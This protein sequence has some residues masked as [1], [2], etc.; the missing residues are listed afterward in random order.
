[1]RLLTL[2]FLTSLCTCVRAQNFH[3]GVVP[4]G[5][6]VLNRRPF[7][8]LTPSGDLVLLDVRG[9]NSKI[10]VFRGNNKTPSEEIKIGMNNKD[11]QKVEV[12]PDGGLIVLGSKKKSLL[13]EWFSPE[14]DTAYLRHTSAVEFNN[15]PDILSCFPQAN[16]A[17]ALFFT[18]S[19]KGVGKTYRWPLKLRRDTIA[20][21]P[22][23]V[24][25]PPEEVYDE[26]LTAICRLPNGRFAGLGSD[27]NRFYLQYFGQSGRAE[28]GKLFLPVNLF[29]DAQT[30][31]YHP[32]TKGIVV[33][34]TKDENTPWWYLFDLEGKTI[35]GKRGTSKNASDLQIKRILV[36]PDNS[37]AFLGEQIKASAADFPDLKTIW[38]ATVGEELTGLTTRVPSPDTWQGEA[39]YL[40]PRNRLLATGFNV[41]TKE[42]ILGRDA[43]ANQEGD[44]SKL[45]F[46]PPNLIDQQG[47]KVLDA[48]EAAS[49]ALPWASSE[50]R[51]S[52]IISATLRFSKTIPGLP[53]EIKSNSLAVLG[54]DQGVIHIPLFGGKDLPSGRH[55][56]TIEL[57]H[58]GQFVSS[59][60]YTLETR[61]VP[62]SNV[63]FAKEYCLLSFL[64]D[65]DSASFQRLD[66]LEVSLRVRNDGRKT[67]TGINLKVLPI[68]HVTFSDYYFEF[69]DLAP[70]EYRDTSVRVMAHSYFEYEDL[71]LSF[72][73]DDD[74][75]ANSF[76]GLN[77]KLDNVFLMKGSN[78]N[79]IVPEFIDYPNG[80]RGGPS[81]YFVPEISY[82]TKMVIPDP[83]KLEK[84]TILSPMLRVP[85]RFQIRSSQHFTIESIDVTIESKAS[86]K[87][88]SCGGGLFPY[89]LNGPPHSNIYEFQ[90]DLPVK[91]EKDTYY[92]TF[93]TDQG[94]V[95]S[96]DTLHIEPQKRFKKNLHICMIAPRYNGNEPA[97]L[98]AKMMDSLL[99]KHQLT[100]NVDNRFFT[101]VDTKVILNATAEN[102]YNYLKLKKATIK[103]QKTTSSR[104]DLY[105]DYFLFYVIAHG[106]V[107]EK[108]FT[109]YTSNLDVN[110]NDITADTISVLTELILPLADL[111]VN[112]L[113]MLDACYSGK[114]VDTL[115]GID[116]TKSVDYKFALRVLAASSEESDWKKKGEPSIFSLEL[117]KTLSDLISDK[118][119]IDGAVAAQELN[120]A[121]LYPLTKTLKAWRYEKDKESND[122]ED[123][124]PKYFQSKNAGLPAYLDYFFEIPAYN[125]CQ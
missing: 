51:S 21:S 92:V 91:K 59:I 96:R 116:F 86:G 61:A 41:N 111:P 40:L 105:H 62:R 99:R 87:V 113:Y 66:T 125:G 4:D 43:P 35:R 6:L 103:S 67:G 119:D 82:S 74:S 109:L 31:C 10:Y 98:S 57:S 37:L 26:A 13:L 64:N 77:A 8:A 9:E 85:I 2:L 65:R 39:L 34:G 1:M 90:T 124:L 122:Y 19:K 49:L 100:D 94:R 47:D 88:Q 69:L 106:K 89:E 7:T 117:M 38:L 78:D 112:K 46:S 84:S 32:G 73:L 83:G 56:A 72:F 97:E 114:L 107:V 63:V 54:N 80:R 68:P 44:S 25:S 60:T 20:N 76:T 110:G 42:F 79:Q 11:V 27:N 24:R 18:D 30:L 58:E 5:G 16:G 95:I 14:L 104:D 33:A 118:E 75:G 23:L 120:Q 55:M 12:T 70:G 36:R 93:F 115:S 53:R 29:D 123:Y 17:T 48:G 52:G 81:P 15:K 22:T 101:H 108:D 71:A 28:G 50:D 121:I 102:I 45:T 3:D